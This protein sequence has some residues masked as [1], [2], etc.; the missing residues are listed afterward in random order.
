MVV[1]GS[2][3]RME[4]HP[5]DHLARVETG[6]R[7]IGVEFVEIGDAHRKI[8]VGEQLDRLSLGVARLQH[9]RVG[10]ERRLTQQRGELPG[11][12]AGVADDDP[13][14]VEIVVERLPLAQEFGRKDD[15]VAAE[16]SEEH[17]SELQSLMR[18]SY[19]VF[20]VKK[21]KDDRLTQ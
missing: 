8:S 9:R 1:E 3:P 21:K 17:T 10:V 13:R 4:A 20:F 5:L 6:R 2:D 15:R 14:R 7:G 18:K 19:A 12:R 11:A 16:R